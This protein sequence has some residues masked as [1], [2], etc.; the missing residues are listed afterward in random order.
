L[1]G[2]VNAAKG[3]YHAIDWNREP[4]KDKCWKRRPTALL[5]FM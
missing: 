3:N 2:D 5:T 1:P 4:S